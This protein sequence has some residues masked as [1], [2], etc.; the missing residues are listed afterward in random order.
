MSGTLARTRTKMLRKAGIIPLIYIF[1]ISSHY[2]ENLQP[3]S[4][5]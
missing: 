1:D 5:K 3:N 4:V 2:S